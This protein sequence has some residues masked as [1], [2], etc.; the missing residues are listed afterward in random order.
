MRNSAINQT[1]QWLEQVII[2]FNFCPFAKKE[3]VNNTIRYHL[4]Q[5]KKMTVVL[6][7][8][9]LQLSFLEKNPEIETTLFIIEQGVEQFD[10]YLML[11]DYANQLLVMEGYEGVF[12]IASFHPDYVF[13][14]ESPDD[15]SNF[16]NR[17]PLPLL[18]I[19]REKS[20][21]KVLSVYQQPELIP[22]NNIELAQE[23]GANYFIDLLKQ[24]KSVK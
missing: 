15:A 8:F 13:E 16:T 3:F 4:C 6:E 7:E 21:E 23:K 24:I 9:Y 2:E 12:Q 5:E 19:I 14:G 18:H 20:M 22:E 17:S 10:D 11:L 1:K